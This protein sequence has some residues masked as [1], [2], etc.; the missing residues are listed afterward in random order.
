MS[1]AAVFPMNMVRLCIDECRED[2]SGRVYSKLM[3]AP[4]LFSGFGVLLLKM[5]ALFDQ[6]G[7]P[8]AFQVRRT[9]LEETESGKRHG[10]PE[11]LMEDME[12]ERQSGN[13]RTFDII[14]QSRSQSG[15]QGILM[16]P[17][18][19]SVKKFRS[20]MELLD[21]ISSDLGGRPM[22]EWKMR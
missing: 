4:L 9:F 17:D 5:D 6:V 16:D 18:R 10:I 12:L 15:W 20:E 21:C 14:I 22:R 13:C 2:L 8:Q 3:L 19:T 11:Q 7:Y 1:S